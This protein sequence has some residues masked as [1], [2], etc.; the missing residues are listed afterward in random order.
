M[1]LILHFL[2]KHN[3]HH[4]T[5]K[6]LNSI[7]N[8]CCETQQPC[9]SSCHIVYWMRLHDFTLL[10]HTFKM[11]WSTLLTWQLIDLFESMQLKSLTPLT[12][13]HFPSHTFFNF[14]LRRNFG[15]R[16]APPPHRT[17]SCNRRSIATRKLQKAREHR[18]Q[19][20]KT[21][22]EV[23]IFRWQWLEHFKKKA[24]HFFKKN[25]EGGNW[26]ENNSGAL[27]WSV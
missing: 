8:S 1:K 18:R 3:S 7:T 22:N 16:A 21:K 25:V 11:L 19:N 13:V 2:K 9:D 10:D 12:R 5:L 27:R 17:R 6:R 23:H 24:K 26:N 14:H 20:W 15:G 4:Q